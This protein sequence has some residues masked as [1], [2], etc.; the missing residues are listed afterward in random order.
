[1]AVSGTQVALTI[2]LAPLGLDG[3]WA[4]ST[5]LT[6]TL[7]LSDTQPHFSGHAE[8]GT[9]SLVITKDAKATFNEVDYDLTIVSE[10]NALTTALSGTALSTVF[11][12]MLPFRTAVRAHMAQST[13]VFEFAA[14]ALPAS[15]TGAVD[16]PADHLE[17][18]DVNPPGLLAGDTIG[19]GMT[20]STQIECPNSAPYCTTQNET[21]A[22]GFCSRSCLNDDDCATSMGR[23]VCQLQITDVPN[24][25]G[26]VQVCAI[27][28]ASAA[29]PALLTCSA[30]LHD[31]AMPDLCFPPQP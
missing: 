2:N 16:W 5:G 30:H 23:G 21:Q 31:A 15:V 20:C 17:P 8:S 4:D 27:E 3:N 14:L 29:C 11:Q 9:E 13:A 12:R 24:V 28:C 22:R 25:M 7:H 18:A 1:M 10:R 26:A 19:L 6:A